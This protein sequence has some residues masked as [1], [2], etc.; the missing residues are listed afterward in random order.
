MV[1][2]STAQ[3]RWNPPRDPARDTHASLESAH[4][5]RTT[6]ADDDLKPDSFWSGLIDDV[7]IYNRAIEP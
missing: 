1:S 3:G 7:R 6:G 4:S 2:S 5:K